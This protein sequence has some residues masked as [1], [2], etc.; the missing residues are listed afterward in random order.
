MGLVSE[1]AL[2]DT[3]VPDT[4]TEGVD[5]DALADPEAGPSLRAFLVLTHRPHLFMGRG[6]TPE[7]VFW[8]RYYWFRRFVRLRVARTGPNAGLEQQAFAI[9]EYPEPDCS[10]DWSD[11]AWVEAL[12]ERDAADRLRPPR[13]AAAQPGSH[14]IAEADVGRLARLVGVTDAG[15]WRRHIEAE[16]RI[17]GLVAGDVRRSW[18]ACL[19]AWLEQGRVRDLSRAVRVPKYWPSFAKALGDAFVERYWR[20]YP[21]LLGLLERHPPDSVEYLCAYDLLEGVLHE[22]ASRDLAVPEAIFAAKGPL[23][24]VIRRELPWDERQLDDVGRS[25]ARLYAEDYGPDDEGPDPGSPDD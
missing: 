3:D 17:P 24:P 10:P 1:E 23:P 2:A 22:F 9:L 6:W 14:P 18:A 4:P 8:S 25:L 13:P 12:A 7:E 20:D 11:L 16:S 15:E 5:P 21:F 19:P